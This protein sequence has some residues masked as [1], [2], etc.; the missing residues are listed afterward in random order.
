MNLIFVEDQKCNPIKESVDQKRQKSQV[1]EVN[2]WK[3]F[4]LALC[5]SIHTQ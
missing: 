1:E 2:V 5:F 3:E 4:Q